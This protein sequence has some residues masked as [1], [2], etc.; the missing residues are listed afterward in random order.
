[1][2]YHGE[3]CYM[4]GFHGRPACCSGSPRMLPQA[5]VRGAPPTAGSF[6]DSV[7]AIMP[8]VNTTPEKHDTRLQKKKRVSPVVALDNISQDCAPGGEKL[9]NR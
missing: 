5:S 1:M 9:T 3:L 2:R 6:A 8:H 7:V 4:Q